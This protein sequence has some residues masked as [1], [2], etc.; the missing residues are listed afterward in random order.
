DELEH[1]AAIALAHPR[2]RGLAHSAV[3]VVDD[4]HGANHNAPLARWLRACRSAYTFPDA[5]LAARAARPACERSAAARERPGGREGARAA[6][7]AALRGDSAGRD[8]AC[9]W[10]SA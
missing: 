4:D 7:A 10:I 3:R 6:R 5:P 8:A 9:L 2:D 1:A